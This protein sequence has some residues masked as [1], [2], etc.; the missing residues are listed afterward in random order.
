[1]SVE[2]GQN[3]SHYQILEKLGEGGM[4]VVYRALDIFLNRNVALKFLPFHLTSDPSLRKHFINEA[5][6]A[7]A[8]DHPN[9]CAI[10]EI[11]EKDDGQLFISMAYYEGETLKDKITKGPIEIDEAIDIVLQ[12]S[13]GLRNAHI[14]GIIHLDIKPANIFITRDGI[15]KILDFG[16][17]KAKDQTKL[18]NIEST[19]GTIN[20]MSPEQA[21]GGKVDHRTDIWAIGAI[22]YEMITGKQPF[23]G[24]YDQVILFLIMNQHPKPITEMRLGVSTELEQIVSKAL[25]KYPDERYQNVDELLDDLR[26]EQKDLNDTGT[27]YISAKWI[28]SKIKSLQ[29]RNIYG[30]VILVTIA[31]IIAAIFFIYKPYKEKKTQ[32]TISK[33]TGN[34]LA[35]MY[36]EN[37]TDPEDKDHTGEMLTNLLI[38]SLSQVKELKVISRERLMDIQKEMGPGD[39]K[40]LLPNLAGQI[41]KNAGVSTM[42]IGSILQEKP[43]LS[44][45]ISVID[46]QSGRI[47]SSQ[48]VS[49]FPKNKIFTLVDSLTYLLSNDFPVISDS[50]SEIKNVA[51]VT[52]NSLEAYRAYVEGLTFYNWR[53][54]NEAK[55]A[56]ERAV[57]LDNNFAMAYFYLSLFQQNDGEVLLS[58]KSFQKA[59]ELTDNVTECERLQIIARNYAKLNKPDKA[60]EIFNQV[61]ERD[62]HERY[63]YSYLY[64]LY[65][66]DFLKPEKAI[67]I[68]RLAFN[69]NPSFKRFWN[70]LAYSFTFLNKRDEA[71]DAIN[72]YINL[73][74]SEPNPYDSKGD[75]YVWFMNYDS[76]IV[77]Y[78]KAIELHKDYF[79]STD[80]GYYYLL[81]QN[82][83]DALQYFN[84]SGYQMPV[85]E[86]HHGQIT[87]AQNELSG[88]MKS[89]I[90]RINLLMVLT[91]MIHLSYETRQYSEMLQLA[92]DLSKELKKD[93]G[94]KIYGRNYIVW[95][96][97]KQG[98]YS[99]AQK[100]LDSIRIDIAGTTPRLQFK[101]DY[102]SAVILFEEGNNELAL[103]QFKKA[104]DILPPNHEPNFF[105]SVCLLKS[106]QL[107]EAVSEFQRLIYWPAN[108]S[109]YL[110]GDILGV[111]G[112]WPIQ[113]VK[114]HYWLG[115]AY[116]QQ[117]KKEEAIR[118]Y[119]K[120]L[121]IWKD[122]DFTS[123]ELTDAKTRV[124]K[125]KRITKEQV[126]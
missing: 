2:I 81:R 88:L 89:K 123:P 42:L 97:V 115:V 58:W 33:I 126:R 101:T 74:P 26:R 16:L 82:Y 30:A 98:R 94:E 64:L 25:A 108:V 119:D 120:F 70:A 87:I 93:P 39:S 111:I 63:P 19:G 23:K 69:N 28:S 73:A 40:A 29:N 14:T 55:A 103:K 3:L 118:E 76:S 84:M 43:L 27:K 75:L 112:Y 17:A 53:Y 72:N 105:Y 38:T 113:A 124:V 65:T 31:I 1:M 22:L 41:A 71:F 79:S 34:S 99:E 9:I 48:K 90:S 44:V 21:R 96:L 104:F 107:S 47:I 12:L 109:N 49:N 11:C 117:N 54:Y 45:T 60:I 20:Y 15:V 6:T 66:Y 46:V 92:N 83:K 51:K 18:I 102:L 7:S 110:V 59:V 67:E 95:A 56:F 24:D 114:A 91:Q 121:D 85:I 10:H 35:V 50:K 57:E 100:L 106:G 52:T 77:E 37:I 78:Q 61:I 32:S 36:F 13:E 4:G 86:I 122:T 116:E 5:Q 68:C 62:P 80:L 8:L 125:L